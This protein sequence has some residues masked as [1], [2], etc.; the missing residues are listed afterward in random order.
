MKI[1]ESEA[2]MPQWYKLQL[3]NRRFIMI[4]LLLQNYFALPL[5]H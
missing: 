4:K 3:I 1:K 2:E 5:L